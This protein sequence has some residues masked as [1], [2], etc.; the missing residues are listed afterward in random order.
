MSEPTLGS[1]T[2]QRLMT[3]AA[4]R[5]TETLLSSGSKVAIVSLVTAV[6]G[7]SIAIWFA[8][9]L[10]H[11]TD[12]AAPLGRATATLDSAIPESMAALRGWIAY[13]NPESRSERARIWREEIEPALVRLDSLAPKSEVAGTHEIF[14]TLKS[15]LR[16]LQALQWA[17][18]D[19]A[20]TPGN[21][22]ASVLYNRRLEP[23]RREMSRA[24]GAAIDFVEKAPPSREAVDFMTHLVDFRSSVTRGDFALNQLLQDYDEVRAQTVHKRLAEARTHADM[25]EQRDSFRRSTDLQGWIDLAIADFRAYDVLVPGVIELRDSKSWNV[26]MM[27][28]EEEAVPLSAETTQISEELFTAQSD[29]TVENADL[30][31]RGAFAIIAMTL[32]M[33]FVSAASIF[34]SYRLQKRVKGVIARAQRLGQYEI[35]ASIGSGGMGNVYLAKHAMLRRPSALKLLKA[36]D[37]SDLR[38]QQRFQREVQLTSQ[39]THPNTIEIY[40]YGRTPEGIFYYAMEHVDGFTIQALVTETGPVD[41]A[42]VVH[43]LLQACGSLDEAHDRGLLHRDIKPGNIMLTVRG[44]LYDT[45]K[46]LDFGLVRDLAGEDLDAAE[47]RNVI[48][49]TPM[50]MA[51]EIVLASESAGP[52]ADLYA[53]AAVG[54]FMLAGTTLFPPGE[55]RE[56]LRKQVD[57]DVPFPS[58]RL[59]RA[60]PRNLEYVIMGALAK[61][62]AERPSS[63]ARFAEMLRACE[64]D[65]WSQKEAL[66]WWEDYAE[67]LGERAAPVQLEHLRSGTRIE[68]AVDGSASRDGR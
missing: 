67:A 52:A 17:I 4:H 35:E 53:L 25:I 46:I 64:L 10:Q 57:E 31:S 42:R 51:P 49:G 33:A 27:L 20:N 38:A 40:D 62:P 9:R 60:L 66:F 55:V 19:V 14:I 18:E 47:E 48:V 5:L 24:I 16:D 44:G 34:V 32:A 41:P 58:E 28:A 6:I 50:Y 12:V 15:R 43:V 23:I 65:D 8:F 7:L 26:A 59:G 36:D 2:G 22:P 56:L 39:L 54:Y 3:S 68:V 63:A 1:S 13:G 21:E 30:M 45:V 29:R 61:N 11:H 37:A